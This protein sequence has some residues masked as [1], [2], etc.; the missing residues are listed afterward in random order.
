M[1]ISWSSCN[2]FPGLPPDRDIH[3]VGAAPPSRDH[4]SIGVREEAAGPP[5]RCI[6]DRRIEGSLR[7]RHIA[8]VCSGLADG[9]NGVGDYCRRLAEA[10]ASLGVQCDIVAL[11][12]PDCIDLVEGE[13]D[14]AGERPAIRTARIPATF[15]VA[16]RAAIAAAILRRWQPDWVSLQFVCYGFNRKGIVLRA[17]FWL[18]P[19]LSEFRLAVMM[20]ELW[21]GIP[22][23]TGLWQRVVGAV[24]RAAILRL[25]RL[26]RPAAIATSNPY[27]RAVL[28]RHAV[29]A[30]L[31][32]LMGNI[33]VTAESADS[34]LGDAI[35][36]AGGPYPWADRH[37]FLLIGMFGGIAGD[38][39]AEALITRL[40]DW[41]RRQ[42]RR[43]VI[44]SAGRAGPFAAP[45]FAQ[46]KDHHPDMDFVIIGPRSPREISQF[47][48]SVDVGLSSYPAFVLGRSGSAAAMLE[49]GLPVI[50]GRGHS[51]KDLPSVD[52]VFAP[53]VWPDDA[54]LG[55][56]LVGPPDRQTRHDWPT[57]VARRLLDRLEGAT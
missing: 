18:P 1:A 41:A 45:L 12:D 17:L 38:W 50:V 32:P 25:L 3:Y 55:E 21:L 42:Q 24:Q 11:A 5:D 27:Y 14:L 19:L 57:I 20:H 33:P 54:G 22:P 43:V 7:V 56:R 31:L 47:F 28:A 9:R 49:H 2:G 37:R 10:L 26:L 4:A 44:V 52:P 51:S 48:N 13:I 53:M 29:I 23:N 40:G 46:W 8:F 16:R 36:A 15:G 6:D 35:R 30:D 39:Q 34:W